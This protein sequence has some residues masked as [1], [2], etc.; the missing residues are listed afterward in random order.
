MLK[1]LIKRSNKMTLIENYE[2]KIAFFDYISHS[3]SENGTF[4]LTNHTK[5]CSIIERSVGPKRL[6]T[7]QNWFQTGLEQVWNWFCV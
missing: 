3:T 4:G 1:M 5:F 2:I 6:I 7:E